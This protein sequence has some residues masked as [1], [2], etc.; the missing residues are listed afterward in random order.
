MLLPALVS[1]KRT[2]LKTEQTHFRCVLTSA[3]GS[4][5]AAVLCLDTQSL[6]TLWGIRWLPGQRITT[7]TRLLVKAPG[8]RSL[9]LKLCHFHMCLYIFSETQYRTSHEFMP[10]KLNSAIARIFHL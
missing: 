5:I 4:E 10:L 8:S 7:H 3:E 6:V 1:F 2:E 9:D